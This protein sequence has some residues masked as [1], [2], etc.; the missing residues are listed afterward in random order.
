MACFDFQKHDSTRLFFDFLDTQHL[1]DRR[2]SISEEFHEVSKATVSPT[3][4]Y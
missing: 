3:L 2:P 1:T 4:R